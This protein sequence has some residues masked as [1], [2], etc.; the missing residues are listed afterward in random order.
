MTLDSR[1]TRAADSKG[2]ISVDV[3]VV[4]TDSVIVLVEGLLVLKV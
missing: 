1:A 2:C 3:D 4:A